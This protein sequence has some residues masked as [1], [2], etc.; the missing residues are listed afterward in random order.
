MTEKWN[1]IGKFETTSIGKEE[2]LDYFAGEL[3][4]FHYVT[5]CFQA[6]SISSMKVE[7]NGQSER[8]GKWPLYCN[9]KEK[10]TA[11]LEYKFVEKPV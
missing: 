7:E 4:D 8:G 3:I 1:R 6:V 11:I 2:I 10:P 5:Y 9:E